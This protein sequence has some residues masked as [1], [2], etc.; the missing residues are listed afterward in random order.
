MAPR[1]RHHAEFPEVDRAEWVTVDVA[2][3]KLVKGQLPVLDALKAHL[4]P[5]N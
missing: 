4:E 1:L 2:R 3:D 5:A